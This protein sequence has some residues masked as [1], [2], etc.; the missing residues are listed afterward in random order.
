M[1][2]THIVDA[3]LANKELERLED[4]L[5]RSRPLLGV[6]LEELRERWMT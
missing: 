3:W 5:K 4:Y 1:E 6:P 2:K